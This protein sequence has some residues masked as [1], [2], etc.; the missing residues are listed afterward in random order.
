MVVVDRFLPGHCTAC[1]LR[2]AAMAFAARKCACRRHCRGTPE[3]E[4][5]RLLDGARGG[6]RGPSRRGDRAYFNRCGGGAAPLGSSARALSL[7]LRHRV[8][9]PA[10]HSAL[11]RRRRAA[12]VHHRA[13]GRHHLRSDQDHRRDPR[14]APRGV[15]RQRVDVPWRACAH[16][17]GAEI[18]H[19]LLPLDIGGRRDRRHRGRIDRA[20]RLQ[21]GGGISDPY[22]ACGAVPAGSRAAGQRLQRY[23]LFGGLAAAV[24]VLIVCALYPVALSETT[25]NWT[26]ATLLAASA[27]FWR[28]PLPFAA[29]IAFILLAY[30]SIVEQPGTTSVRS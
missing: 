14:R 27:L 21:L 3:L 2:G 1:R 22:C 29:T 30:H 28:A 13:R 7:D 26:V 5:R 16:E 20:L 18:S 10:D 23:F 15:L 19:R 17:A 9:T 11:A 6:A 4:G 25:F 12:F 24:L 8:C